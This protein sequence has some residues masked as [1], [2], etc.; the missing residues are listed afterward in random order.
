MTLYYTETGDPKA[1]LIVFLHG[2]GVSGWMWKKQVDYFSH[3]HCLIPDLPEQGRSGDN[4]TFSIQRCAEQ[5][6]ELMG[7]KGKDKQII[8]IGFSLGA[9]VLIEML[10]QK[11]HLIDFGMINSA[12]V[13]PIPFASFLLKSLKITYPLVKIKFF[14]KIQAKSMYIHRDDFE[15]YYLESSQMNRETFVRIMEENMSFTIPENFKNATGNILVTVG[16]KER[17][18]MKES[19]SALINSHSNCKGVIFPKVGHGMS[20]AQPEIF[21]RLVV[22]WIEQGVLPKEMRATI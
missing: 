8:V 4:V 18:I 7:E 20:L 15:T 5:I 19:F 16:E 6:I 11:P 12:L 3:Y 13:K 1:P 21:N 14:S 22:G 10:S 9:Q 17:K 2:G